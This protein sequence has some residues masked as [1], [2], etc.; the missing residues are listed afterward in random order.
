MSECDGA[1]GKLYELLRGEL[2]AEESAPI[3]DHLACCP[4][5]QS[6]QDVCRQ[7]MGV[8]KRAC[9]EER[10]SNCPPTQLRDDILASLR[11]L[12]SEQPSA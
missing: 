10:D 3:R 4:D 9:V 1:K 12:A 8:V 11:G 5:C 6:E 2:C 7:L